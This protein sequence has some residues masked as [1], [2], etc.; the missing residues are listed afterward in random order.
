M[1]TPLI[2]NVYRWAMLQ[3]QIEIQYYP[4]A[5]FERITEFDV[6]SVR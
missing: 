1:T 4:I 3:S 2:L 5:Y 6:L